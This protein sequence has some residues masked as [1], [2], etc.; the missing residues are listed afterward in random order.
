[1]LHDEGGL[2]WD[3]FIFDGP[4]IEEHRIE[5]CIQGTKNVALQI[6]A[7]HECGFATGTRLF[8]GVV[9]VGFRGFVHPS[10]LAQDNGV[11]VIPETAGI[12]FLVLHFV[13]TVAAHVHPIAPLLQVIHHFVSTADDARLRSAEV[14]KSVTYFQAEFF[15]NLNPFA[16]T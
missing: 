14:Q 10:V 5:A 6:V 7:Y 12:K 13:E 8:E 16:Y 3:I 2:L 4:A 15:C 9:E 11:E 1:M